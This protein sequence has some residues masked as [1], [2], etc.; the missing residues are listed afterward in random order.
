MFTPT[1]LVEEEV[2]P[3]EEASQIKGVNFQEGVNL[4]EEVEVNLQEVVNLQEEVEAN[5]QEGVNQLEEVVSRYHI[6]F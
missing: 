4:Q 5:L 6:E 2:D 1:S 3:Q